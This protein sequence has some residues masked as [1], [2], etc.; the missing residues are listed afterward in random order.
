MEVARKEVWV[1]YPDA[2]ISGPDY[3]GSWETY[4]AV[5]NPLSNPYFN[6]EVD[7]QWPN[8]YNL[9]NYG[10]YVNVL[11]FNNAT[12]T[13]SLAAC[14]SCG[15]DNVKYK[16]VYAY[17]Y[18]PSQGPP[19]ASYPNP[20]NDILTVEIDQQGRQQT[21]N[22]CYDIRLYNIHGNLVRQI[23]I[24]SANVQINVA[25]LPDGF[26]Y[27]HVYDETGNAQVTKQTIVVKH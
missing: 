21:A 12:Y 19:V 15:C 10:N 20:V 4:Y 22:L 25:N 2:E 24:Q 8:D 1:G 6:W 11:F 5:C 7:V 23:N 14:N 18:S 13:V 27:L 3:A 26:Y 9:Y 17:P 16:D